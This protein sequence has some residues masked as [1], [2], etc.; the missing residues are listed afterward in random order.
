MPMSKESS[1]LFS[2]TVG[3]KTG[4]G[5]KAG[6]ITSAPPG[7]MAGI[8]VKLS[9]GVYDTGIKVYKQNEHIPGTKQFKPGKSEIHISLN[10]LQKLINSKSGTG[11]FIPKTTKERVD[12]GKVIGI[13]ID[14]TTGKSYPTNK[15]FI[16]Y[17]KTGT[18]V[19]PI[20]P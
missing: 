6:T 10:E 8:Y 5:I 1:G 15:G 14:G 11:T 12:F 13:W 20:R 9:I 17:S 19:V 7:K 3:A 18:H 4:S 16:I 2:G